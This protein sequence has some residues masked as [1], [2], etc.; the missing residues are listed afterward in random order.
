MDKIWKKFFEAKTLFEKKLNFG[1]VKIIFRDSTN[2]KICVVKISK[3]EYI[4]LH[5]AAVA[6]GMTDQEFILDSI[7]EY[8]FF[9]N[10]KE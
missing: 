8:I 9:F 2:K 6:A 5:G 7:M 10:N 1:K 4:F 3:T